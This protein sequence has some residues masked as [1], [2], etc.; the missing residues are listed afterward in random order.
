MYFPY[1]RGKQF[2]L[3]AL[4]GVVPQTF[5][6]T[7]PIIEPVVN[8]TARRN[9]YQQWARRGATFIFI[10]NPQHPSANRLTTA[11]TQSIIDNDFANHPSVIVGFIIEQHTTVNN[12]RNFL[13]SNPLKDKAIIFRHDPLPNLLASITQELQVTPVEYLIFDDKKTSNATRGVFA[14]HNNKVLLTDGFQ[15][16]NRNA[17]YPANSAFA[18]NY[19]NWRANGWNGIGDYLTIG[20]NFSS[21]GGPAYVVTCHL[22]VQANN[23]LEVY[24]FSS[25]T[26]SDIKGQVPDKFR[27]ACSNLVNSAV[28]ATLNSTG[29]DMY[30]DWHN[31]DHNPQLGAAKQASMQHH[32]ELLANIV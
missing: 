10:V 17:D 21:G 32:I 13:T 1:I 27:E 15:N 28:V 23:G 18:S 14:N 9:Q 2:E 8:N 4:L 6:N 31:R 30:R 7:F 24:H 25:T 19:Q 5:D 12:L 20:D 29:L 3:N 22:T 26:D 11:V 16:Q